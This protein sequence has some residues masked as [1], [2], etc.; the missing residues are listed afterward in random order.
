[1]REVAHPEKAI[2]VHALVGNYRW[3]A[4]ESRILLKP[5]ADN[6][7][8]VIQ[9]VTIADGATDPI[10][11]GLTYRDFEI[12]PDGRQIAVRIPGKGNIEVYPLR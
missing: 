7:S 1:V 12:S 8:N 2:K 5:G 10:L 11:H 3:S 6:K 9:W 4:D